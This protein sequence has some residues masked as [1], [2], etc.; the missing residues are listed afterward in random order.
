MFFTWWGK[1]F[2]FYLSMMRRELEVSSLFHFLH[3]FIHFIPAS[4]SRVRAGEPDWGQEEG[5]VSASWISLRRH[6]GP[7]CPA[8]RLLWRLCQE[9]G[10]ASLAQCCNQYAK[11]SIKHTTIHTSLRLCIY[12]VFQLLS[13]VQHF[14]ANKNILCPR[15]HEFV[16]FT[17]VAARIRERLRWIIITGWRTETFCGLMKVSKHQYE[18]RRTRAVPDIYNF[19]TNATSDHFFHVL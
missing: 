5:G 11:V 9:G 10:G 2:F 14:T 4:I 16:M 13:Q 18:Q 19:S 6:Q 15:H 12:L 3:V 17:E 7:G 1:F 8:A